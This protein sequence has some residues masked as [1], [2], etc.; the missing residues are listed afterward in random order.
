M[1]IPAL[2]RLVGQHCNLIL[3]AEIRA[4]VRV[5]DFAK[6]PAHSSQ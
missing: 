1:Q 3:R 4:R 2:L 6:Q 5:L